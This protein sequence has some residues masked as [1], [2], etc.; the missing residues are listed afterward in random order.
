MLPCERSEYCSFFTN[1]L[2]DLPSETEELRK[3]F[4]RMNKLAC[5]RYMV[6][7]K[8]REGFAPRDEAALSYMDREMQGMYPHDIIR[9]TR[10]I[11]M[12]TE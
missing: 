6:H 10:I 4:C 3:T 12:L 1:Q 8:L 11:S 7:K 9:A 2:S 5:A